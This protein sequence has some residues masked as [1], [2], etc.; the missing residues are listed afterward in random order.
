MNK[1]RI[2]Q[3]AEERAAASSHEIISA[4]KAGSKCVED[5]IKQSTSVVVRAINA[6]GGA[7]R[8]SLIVKKLEEV[9]SASLATNISI[10][11]L[12]QKKEIDMSS[13][14]DLLSKLIEEFKKPCEIKVSLKLK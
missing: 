2:H 9:K 8:D 5:S 13:T 12:G 11:K 14:N 6:N 10:K 4:V 7:T 1:H 3:T